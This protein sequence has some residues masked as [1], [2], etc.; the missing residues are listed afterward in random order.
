M[1]PKKAIIIVLVL[2]LILATAFCV[3]YN[4]K[5][6][7]TSND[8]LNANPA[9]Q[10][11]EVKKSEP[12]KPK[13]AVEEKVNKIIENAKQNPNVSSDTVKQEIIST[14]NAE[15]IS[16][17]QN[18]TPEQ[19]AADLKAQEERQRIINQINEQIKK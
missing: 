7:M 15:I 16:Q 9:G 14:I 8:G 2:F 10:I 18:K 6:A 13:E 11:G 19:K 17:E 3:L 5:Q 1:T 4:K 12:A